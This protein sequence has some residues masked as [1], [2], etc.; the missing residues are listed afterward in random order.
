M[1]KPQFVNSKGERNELDDILR[2]PHL[3][4]YYRKAVIGHYQ[5]GYNEEMIEMPEGWIED[6]LFC[7]GN[8][9]AAK[10]RNPIGWFFT[11]V[12]PVTLDRYNRPYSW[13]TAADLNTDA[14]RVFLMKEQKNPVLVLGVSMMEQIRPLVEIMERCYQ[15]LDQNIIG[16]SQPV[17]I[18]SPVPGNN[19]D[20]KMLEFDLKMGKKYIGCIDKKAVDTTVLDLKADDHTQNLASTIMFLHSKIMDILDMPNANIK[21]S[22]VSDMETGNANAGTSVYN[23][24]GLKRRQQWCDI[25]NGMYPELELSVKVSDAWDEPEGSPGETE[26]DIKAEADDK[27][28]EDETDDNKE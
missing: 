14:D 23:D 22:G 1:T 2:L 5:W 25:M 12:N 17:L 16:M 9:S 15:C 28:E 3:M 18:E 6:S 11:P 10:Y 24:W 7:Y 19:L 20:G 21:S 8:I 26:Q 4:D 13:I 27:T